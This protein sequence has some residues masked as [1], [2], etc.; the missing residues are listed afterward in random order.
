MTSVAQPRTLHPG[1][2]CNPGTA[3]CTSVNDRVAGL[4]VCSLPAVP[5]HSHHRLICEETGSV[6][7][8]WTDTDAAFLE[9]LS[10]SP[11]FSHVA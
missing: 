10:R 1:S 6:I 9:P 4:A 2:T 3:L 11:L 7:G 8:E 5:H